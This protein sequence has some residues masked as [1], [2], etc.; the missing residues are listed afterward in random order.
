MLYQQNFRRVRFFFKC[1]IRESAK[2]NKDL[3]LGTVMNHLNLVRSELPREEMA[4]MLNVLKGS[5]S[6]AE[7]GSE[8]NASHGTFDDL[9]DTVSKTK[10]VIGIDFYFKD[11]WVSSLNSHFDGI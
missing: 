2:G 1:A 6:Q 8:A 11:M 9:M 5:G 7:T 4:R 3:T 10:H